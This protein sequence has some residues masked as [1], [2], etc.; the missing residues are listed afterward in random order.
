MTAYYSVSSALY[1]IGWTCITISHLSILPVLASAENNKVTLNS[2]VY[3]LEMLSTI[4][5]YGSSWIFTGI[6]EKNYLWPV[7][8]IFGILRKVRK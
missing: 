5:I 1:G 7:W 6:G 3:A 8:S 4:C 2:I